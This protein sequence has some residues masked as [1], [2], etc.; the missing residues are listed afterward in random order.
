MKLSKL[1]LLFLATTMLLLPMTGSAQS[2]KI[3]ADKAK[4]A[5]QKLLGE[6]TE[7]VEKAQKKQKDKKDE[8]AFW[9]RDKENLT[10]DRTEYTKKVTK[11]LAV[12]KIEIQSL[13]ETD[14]SVGNR[15]Y[16]KTRVKGLQQNHTYCSEELDQLKAFATE[17]EFRA[18]QRSFDKNLALL[19]DHLVVTMKEAG[20]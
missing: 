17:E 14:S 7:A 1:H 2:G 19:S 12:M 15:E 20:H 6:A 10:M 18:R 9:I 13:A 3:D 11:A 8:S 5:L 16:F 4:D